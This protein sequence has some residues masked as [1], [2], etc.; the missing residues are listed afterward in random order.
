MVVASND[1]E[2]AVIN[3]DIAVVDTHDVCVKDEHVVTSKKKE[4]PHFPKNK[5]K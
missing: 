4:F 1:V 5:I 2:V 3:K